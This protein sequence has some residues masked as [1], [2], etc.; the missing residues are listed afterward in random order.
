MK[1]NKKT[2]IIIGIAAI[3]TGIL[4]TIITVGT[5]NLTAKNQEITSQYNAKSANPNSS[6][7]NKAA[8]TKGL[9]TNQKDRTEVQQTLQ[10]LSEQVSKLQ[11]TQKQ[12]ADKNLEANSNENPSGLTPEEEAEKAQ[13]ELDVAI[14]LMEETV[15][16]EPVDIEWSDSAVASLQ[17]SVDEYSDGGMAI[18]EAEC[19]SS[20]CRLQLAL[21]I[22]NVKASIEAIEESLPWN[23]EMFFQV[24]ESDPGYPEAVF[25]I[26]REDHSLPGMIE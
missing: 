9:N 21:D 26:A 20:L 10:E 2:K 13:E 15:Q 25:Y 12:N 3:V 18:I 17:N 1:I 14:G 23:G 5:G 7:K 16:S 24:D 6:S 11:K 8:Q 4:A 22:D 19:R